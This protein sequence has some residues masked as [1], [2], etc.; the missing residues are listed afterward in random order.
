MSLAIF[1]LDNTLLGGD[2]DYL[3]GQFLVEKGIV[4]RKYYEEANAR[5]YEDYKNGTLDIVKFLEFAL[6]PLADNRP[7]ALHE[8]R[9]AFI[10]EKIRPLLLP[11][12][13]ALIEKHRRAGDIPIIITATNRFVTEP[14]AR[15]YGIEHL[16]ATTP[17]FNGG[18]YTGRFVGT[19]CFREGKVQRLKEWLAENDH[20][21]ADSWFYSD[22]HNDL[23]LLSLVGFPVAVDPDE[24]LATHAAQSCWPIISLRDG[25]CPEQHAALL[26]RTHQALRIK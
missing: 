24:T 26:K 20:N 21:L 1:D 11:A 18:R 14:I 3:W 22:S 9:A 2:S 7:E 17:E 16:I 6:S 8:W 19:P 13:A 5:F 15:L 10:E 12:A 4:D 25:R 23:P